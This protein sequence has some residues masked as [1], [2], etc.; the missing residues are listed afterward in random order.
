MMKALINK[1]LVAGVGTCLLG[2][3]VWLA[4]SWAV[5]SGRDDDGAP[6]TRGVFAPRFA[7]ASARAGFGSPATRGAAAFDRVCDLAEGLRDAWRFESTSEYSVDLSAM[8]AP[9]ATP[10][11]PSRST[12]QGELQ[13]QVLSRDAEG[14]VVLLARWV[15]NDPTTRKVAP[16]VDAPFLLEL[17][18]RC[19]VTRYA[20]L[21]STDVDSARVQQASIF[22]WAFAVPMAETGAFSGRSGFGEYDAK[23]RRGSDSRGQ[24]VVRTLERYRRVWGNDDAAPKVEL[25]RSDLTVRVAPKVW[26]DGFEGEQEL[27]APRVPAAK[28]VWKALR[29][30]LKDDALAGASLN[31]SDYE[32]VDLLPQLPRQ[33]IERTPK[34]LERQQSLATKTYEQAMEVFADNLLASDNIED[35]WRDLTLYLEARP[36]IIPMLQQTLRYQQLPSKAQEVA[37]MSLGKVRGVEARDALRAMAAD[38][39]LPPMDRVRAAISL[40]SRKDVGATE[41]EAFLQQAKGGLHSKNRPERFYARNALLAAGMVAGVSKDPA[42]AQAVRQA[43]A[44]HLG[45]SD[46]RLSRVAFAALGNIGNVQDLSIIEQ[47][48]YD[49]KVEVRTWVPQALRRMPLSAVGP[50]ELAWLKRETAPD[51]KRELWHVLD[52][53]LADERQPLPDEF[54]GVAISDLKAQHPALTRQSLIKLL[55]TVSAKVPEAKVALLAQAPIE[56]EQRS[57]LYAVIAESVEAEELY[58]AM[59]SILNPAIQPEGKGADPM[60][61][62]VPMPTGPGPVVDAVNP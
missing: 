60:S 6:T 56:F 35:Q 28:T 17:D 5:S 33:Q 19:Q 32:W 59:G 27:S 25:R 45:S 62:N 41:T 3:A 11:P 51:V 40:A 26:F 58:R 30:A 13:S 61:P 47:W 29:V 21:K 1:W 38:P 20:R 43:V 14:R 22:D 46:K 55:S 37:F 15:S 57:G 39:S 49:P 16:Q 18:A 12:F 31:V 10:T 23:V 53:Q 48:S 4:T 52:R 54:V 36:E 24:F 50:F 2:G 8:G 9:A 42:A 44:P 34:E 7:D